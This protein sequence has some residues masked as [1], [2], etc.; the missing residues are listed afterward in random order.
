MSEVHLM[1]QENILRFKKPEN[2]EYIFDLKG[3]SVNREVEGH[4]KSSTTLKDVNFM[5]ERK[6]DDHFTQ[7]GRI[8]RQKLLRSLRKD[9]EFL[10]KK[11]IMDYSLLLGIEETDAA[12]D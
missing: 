12:V 3:S 1:L 7:F 2:L 10:R 8:D 4:I 5:K 6:K 9:V 11:G